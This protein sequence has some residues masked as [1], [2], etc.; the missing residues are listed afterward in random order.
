MAGESTV[1]L[2]L[3]ND[4]REQFAL[5]LSRLLNRSANVTR[6]RPYSTVEVPRNLQPTLFSCAFSLN[7]RACLL[8]ESPASERHDTENCEFIQQT[9]NIYLFCSLRITQ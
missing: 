1:V 7:R 6:L 8:N 2:R 5:Y 4:N 9:V 3:D